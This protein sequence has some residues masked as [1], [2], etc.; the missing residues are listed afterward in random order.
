[1]QYLQRKAPGKKATQVSNK[2][3]LGK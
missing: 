3:P 2:A 1:V